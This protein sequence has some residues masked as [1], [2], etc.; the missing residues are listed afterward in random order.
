[1]TWL[2]SGSAT[3]TEAEVNRLAEEIRDA[4]GFPAADLEGFNAHRENKRLD[5]AQES[6]LFRLGDG[7]RESSIPICVPTGDPTPKQ[8]AKTYDVPGFYFRKLTSVIKAAFEGPLAEHFHF[9]PYKLLHKSPVTGKDERIFC[10]V[11]DSDAF[12]EAHEDVQRHGHLPPDDPGCKREK[13]VAALMFWSD[14]TH[15]T[16]FGTAKIWPIYLLFGNVSK[17]IRMRPTSGACHHLAYI[18]SVCTSLRT[19]LA[20]TN[21]YILSSPTHFMIGFRRTT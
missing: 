20:K 10:E 15:L 2:N 18:P 4:G 7:F 14:S 16:D 8:Q 21:S 1:M 12:A 9:S 6:S 3:K 11:Y 17:Y 13:I 5:A 19:G